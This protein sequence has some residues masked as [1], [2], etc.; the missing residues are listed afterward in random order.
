MSEE[1]I[2]VA[3]RVRPLSQKEEEKVQKACWSIPSPNSIIDVSGDKAYVYDRVYPPVHST[4]TIFEELGEK[5]I[6]GV[7][8]GYNGCIFCYGQTGSGKTHTMHGILPKNPGIIPLTIETIF[9]YIHETI[10]KE[11]LV[12]CSYLEIYNECVNDLLDANNT[13]LT[14]REDKNGGLKII[15]LSEKECTSI[16]QVYSLLSL[17]DANRQV[18]STNFNLKSS[19]SHSM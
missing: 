9:A 17:G 10:E 6:W 19:R 12:R 16:N 1:T 11:F 8:E 13:N 14:L 4:D 5:M 18:A 2:T 7:M 3:V 15:D